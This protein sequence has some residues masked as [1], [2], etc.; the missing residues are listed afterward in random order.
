[1]KY[2][3]TNAEADADQW[4]L[5]IMLAARY[6]PYALPGALAKL[7]M[8]T[9]GSQLTSGFDGMAAALATTSLNVRLANAYS[10]IQTAC[11]GANSNLCLGYKGEVHPHLPPNAPLGMRR[12]RPRAATR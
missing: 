4:A 8:A 12:N 1:L 5:N 3:P 10:A 2:V 7:S 9:T 11:G 6:D